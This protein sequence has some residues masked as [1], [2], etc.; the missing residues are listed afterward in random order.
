MRGC[1]VCFLISILKDGS[2]VNSLLSIK[3]SDLSLLDCPY[4]GTQYFLSN[5][6]HI[7][8]V[9]P[10]QVCDFV[11]DLF[12]STVPICSLFFYTFYF[13]MYLR[14]IVYKDVFP[15]SHPGVCHT[16]ALL[17]L[18][19]IMC[20]VPLY[21]IHL[22]IFHYNATV[23]YPCDLEVFYAGHV[24]F[25]LHLHAYYMTFFLCNSVLYCVISFNVMSYTYNIVEY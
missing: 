13:D 11:Y 14:L 15:I 19:L 16:H 2:V 3:Y 10:I 24:I 22:Y 21:S 25:H 5:R 23:S 8:W 18:V 17:F 20:R 9:R 7:A 4:I 6:I 12:F 1:K